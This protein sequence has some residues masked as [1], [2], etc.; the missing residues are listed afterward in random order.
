MS[1]QLAFVGEHQFINVAVLSFRDVRRGLK[2]VDF[3]AQRFDLT[4]QQRHAAV[5]VLHR[6]QAR[7]ELDDVSLQAYDFQRAGAFDLKQ[8]AT[9]DRS[10]GAMRAP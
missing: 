9:A 10:G 5:I 4:A 1:W 7:S 8:S 2:G 3:Y 6:H